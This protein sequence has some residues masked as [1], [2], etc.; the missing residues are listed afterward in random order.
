MSRTATPAADA[1]E[2]VSGGDGKE[3]SCK[4]FRGGKRVDTPADLSQ[5][6]EILKE[7]GCLVWLDVVDPGPNDLSLLQEEFDLH[8]LAIE[9]AIH[10]HQRPKIESYDSYWFLV[11]QG[12]TV[13]EQRVTFHEIAIFSGRNFLVT[14]R[15]E[16]AYEL[17]EIEE[18][19]RSHPEELR[20]GGGF[21]LYTILDT[22]VDGYF[23]VAT[24]LEDRVDDIEE[25]LFDNRMPYGDLF[26][27]IFGLKKDGQR[28]RWAVL[29]MRDILNPII[30]GDIEL[31][32]EEVIAYFRDVYDHAI[33][34][35]DQLDTM[36]EVVNSALEI[37]LAVVA[38][39]N[40]EI[41]KQLTIIAT[42]FLPLSFVVGFFGQNFDFMVRHIS[43]ADAF[44]L[45]GIGTELVTVI[46]MLVV[47]K[48]RGW[49]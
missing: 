41:S 7:S 3:L 47:F 26:P 48:R 44:W 23:P 29:P 45:L 42:I 16:P 40:N 9:D 1:R 13:V 33:R 8:P 36:R 18:R 34:V 37:Q 17:R 10:A 24:L 22:V 5:I 21:L 6:S 15:H 27:E 46:L 32:P 2:T 31:F 12:V 28:F 43:G 49:F 20:R 11:V 14:V 39:R 25:A 35:I 19:W 4:V 38:N 30:R